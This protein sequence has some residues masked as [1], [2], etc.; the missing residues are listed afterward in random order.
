VWEISV[1]LLVSHP[2][3]ISLSVVGQ[4]L[5]F[6]MEFAP[7]GTLMEVVNAVLH[8]EKEVKILFEWCIF[9]KVD[10]IEGIEGSRTRYCMLSDVMAKS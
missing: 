5:C 7:R 6:F 9:I 4:S 8:A 10:F 1:F 2:N 3:L